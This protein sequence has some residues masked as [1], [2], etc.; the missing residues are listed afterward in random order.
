MLSTAASYGMMPSEFWS[1]RP[2]EFWA[3]CRGH[4]WAGQRRME[5]AEA[6][7]IMSGIAHRAKQIPKVGSMVK[8]RGPEMQPM[9]RDSAEAIKARLKKA[10]AEFDEW[11]AKKARGEVKVKKG[12]GR[13]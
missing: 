10:K 13:K 4:E 6:L 7:A 2:W 11:D 3:F 12:G 8:R 1:L 5:E 9:K